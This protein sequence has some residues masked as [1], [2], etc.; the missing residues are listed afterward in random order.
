MAYS[1]N[2]TPAELSELSALATND[3]IIV[4][5]TSDTAEVVKKIT[6]ENLYIDIAS[7]SMTMTNKILTEPTITLKQSASPTPTAEGDIQWDTDGDSIVVGDGATAKTFVPVENLS[8]DISVTTAGVATVNASNVDVSF[9]AATAI[10]AGQPVGVS[11][12]KDGYVSLA[13]Q[14]AK[15]VAHGITS[16]S[17]NY[18]NGDTLVNVGGAKFVRYYYATAGADTLYVQAGEV[19]PTSQTLTLGTAVTVATAFAGFQNMMNICRLDTDKFVVVYCLDSSATDI[20]YRVGTVSGTTITLGTEATLV[21]AASTV[22]TGA[23]MALAQIATDKAVLAFKAVT[24]T[25]AKV[26]AFTVSGTTATA[27]T[28]VALGSQNTTNSTCRV[29]KIGTDKFALMSV[30]TNR[31]D[32]AVGTISGTTIT[33][34]SEAQVSSQTASASANYFSSP[35]SPADDVFIV[36]GQYSSSTALQFIACTVSGTTITAGT[37][38]VNNVSGLSTMVVISSTEIWVSGSGGIYK[39]TR[40]G[41]DLTIS[42]I[43]S[44]V[45]FGENVLYMLDDGTWI[46]TDEAIDATNQEIY[47]EGMSNNFIGVAQNTVSAGQTVDVRV[48]GVDANQAGLSSGSMY[49]VSNGALT[50]TGTTTSLDS[51]AELSFVRA[52]SNTQIII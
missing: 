46:L 6:A 24:T 36:K 8:G 14:S 32:A 10:T 4:G 48:R 26:V 37:A 19:S 17:N 9:L 27:G 21:T 41:T 29:V 42:T 44:L 18:R 25:T 11:N 50:Y 31:I 43:F 13:L 28:P 16:P 45:A 22:L 15:N 1:S 52:L 39:I 40:S 38:N 47:I 51:I 3:T 12:V 49:V 7:A 30:Q 33:L 23:G 2:K 34:G 5:D 20:K 35:V